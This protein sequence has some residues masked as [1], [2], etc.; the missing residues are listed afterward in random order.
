M[1]GRWEGLAEQ[2]PEE[3]AGGARTTRGI[4]TREGQVQ[5]PRRTQAKRLR[6]NRKATMTGGACAGKSGASRGSRGRIAQG[7]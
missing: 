6:I 5:R 4:R 1:S 7:P 3:E 2:G